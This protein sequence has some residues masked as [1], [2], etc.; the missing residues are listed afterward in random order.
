MIYLVSGEGPSDIGALDGHGLFVAG[1]M[2]YFIDRIIEENHSYSA[3]QSG[4][5]QFVHET[6][7][8]HASKRLSSGKKGMSF[9]GAK[10]KKETAF[11]HRNARALARLARVKAEEQNDDQPV[12]ILFRDADG[13]VSQRRGVWEDKVYSITAGFDAEGF[14]RGVPMVP[15]PKSEAWL[16]CAVKD[17]PYQDCQALENTPG[18]DRSPY[19]L[20]KRLCEALNGQDSA[21][22]IND[23]ICSG[24]IDPLQIDMPSFNYFRERLEKSIR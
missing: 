18:N 21:R 2:T 1:P 13:T 4:I 19:A 20:K 15:R 5:I 6:E 24:Q 12:A 16:L 17:P 23:L 22:E 8:S 3:L 9:P 10:S 7:L 11:F 14:D